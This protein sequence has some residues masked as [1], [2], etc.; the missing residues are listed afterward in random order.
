MKRAPPAFAI[1]RVYLFGSFRIE[2]D[3]RV[4]RLPTH[5]IESLLAY[6]L[7]YP[8]PHPREKIAALFWGDTSAKKASD[9][10][11]NSLAVLHKF[12]GDALLTADREIIQINL[13]ARLWVDARV[14]RA[15]AQAFLS[16]TLPDPAEINLE[17]YRG[18]LLANFYDDW[19]APERE[20]LRALYIDA[21][22][23]AAQLWRARSEYER[24]IE[25]ARRVL[26]ADSA[27]ERA[28]QHLMFCFL[29][30]GDRGAALKQYDECARA[31]REDL[32]VEPAPET[33]A[34]YFWIKQTP[35]EFP[36]LAARITNLPIP[37]SSFIGR[38]EAMT[39]VK[40]TLIESRLVT[41]TGPGGSGKTRLAIQV[42]TDLLDQFRDGVWWIELQDLH[43]A[44]LVEPVVA[45]ALGIHP[46][47]N[48]SLIETL[49]RFL[50]SK[51]LLL[52]LDNCEH[53][54]A[55]CAPLCRSLL[56]T[57]AD[58]KILTTSREPLGL[59]GESI[60]PVPT[61]S[62]PDPHALSFA[63]L[64]MSYEAI[65]LFVE[66]ARNVDAKFAL[67]AQNAAP[68]AQICQRLDGIPLAIELAAARVKVL[69]PAQIVTLLDDRFHLLT[70]GNRR[71]L[72]RQQTLRA[73]MDWSYDLLTNAERALFARLAVFANGCTLPAAKS[74]CSMQ[75][76]EGS[77]ENL[78]TAD[79][80]L[81]TDVL[82]LL[83]HLV[84]KSLVIAEEENGAA[85]YRML[86]TITSYARD[87]LMESGEAERMY[88]QHL[89]WM[90][91]AAKEAEPN[92]QGEHEVEWLARLDLEHDNLRA[93][94]DWALTKDDAAS[95][96]EL[97]TAMWYFWFVR[98]YHREGLTR[99]L[100]SLK[101]SQRD[102]LTANSLRAKALNAVGALDWSLGDLNS[103]RRALEDA[104]AL[105]RALHDAASQIVSLKTLGMIVAYQNDFSA[106]RA[107]IEEGLALAREQ[108]N[109]RETGEALFFLGEV[110]LYE[111][112]LVRAKDLYEQG[113]TLLREIR[114]KNILAH[115]LRRLG[116]IALR[117]R[118]YAR[119][120]TLCLESLELNR[121]LN[122]RRGIAASLVGL[123]GIAGAQGDVERAV[124][125][126]GAVDATIRTLGLPFWKADQVEF[127]KHVAFARANLAP[128]DFEARWK[129]G[130]ALT[131]EEAI[132]YS[133]IQE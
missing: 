122:N 32:G 43:D 48:E 59:L 82:D 24:A 132:D 39:H 84:D 13:D 110:A 65:R 118:D 46:A 81:P 49:E 102:D 119:A 22:L 55:A 107:L 85:R 73:V 51:R 64:L 4:F 18:D 12:F 42:A 109:P 61:L 131:L 89:K 123:A 130:R 77:E 17:L 3:A 97:S 87:K 10:L 124:K 99:L 36:A 108:N 40:R 112:D 20:Q 41:L 114:E 31:L 74:V 9:S 128:N 52:A 79:R 104:L 34:L 115:P 33:R 93:A 120:R 72:P 29:V 54:L 28:H 7:L 127:E 45:K 62:V 19:I 94:L 11:R 96:L 1:I 113:V 66:R 129:E 95:A 37:F 27:N 83:T 71:A 106:A 68:I 117:Q 125:I 2:K 26:A 23:R 78:P 60:V 92:L 30:S 6:L 76:A 16:A 38:K 14:F 133:L 5:K 58:L 100:E 126:L 105:G 88:D 47:P 80:L 25:C 67:T 121:Q 103:A 91:A 63:D 50:A 75:K 44:T 111:D 53:L 56:Q 98:G 70:N 116:E 69:A 101:R 21:L 35:P 57:C 8:E 15:Q 86:E 90:I